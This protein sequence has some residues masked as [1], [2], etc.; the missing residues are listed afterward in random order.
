MLTIG[1]MMT[2]TKTTQVGISGRQALDIM[3]LTMPLR[4]GFSQD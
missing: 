4:M 2:M 1:K 3:M